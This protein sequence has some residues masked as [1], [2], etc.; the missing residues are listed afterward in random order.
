MR[1]FV[2]SLGLILLVSTGY[3][4]KQIVLVK[5][6][7]ILARIG[8]GEYIRFKRK[9]RDNYSRGII[10][11]IHQD[12]FRIGDDTTYL[13]NVAAVDAKGMATSGFKIQ[14]SGI[15]LM[16]AGGVLLIS[17]AAHSGEA[18]TGVVIVSGAI[19]AT[20]LVMQ[21]FNDNTFKIGR[22]KKIIVMGN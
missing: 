14:Q 16:V 12:Y 5:K 9:D 18:D 20:G 22:K 13:Y 11:G 7:K 3:A 17:E 10:E 1:A 2:F 15:I 4:Q 6:N 21:F 8:E 19:I